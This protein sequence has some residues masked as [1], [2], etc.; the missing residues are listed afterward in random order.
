MSADATFVLRLSQLTFPHHV[1]WQTEHDGRFVQ[2]YDP[3]RPGK[4]I[5]GVHLETTSDP[6]KAKRFGSE[7]AAGEFWH[8]S[9]GRR[10]D[11]EPDRPLTA[12]DA[13]I[14]PLDVA[15]AEHRR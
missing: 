9:R 8:A 14:L 10:A 11:G 6:L 2:E 4:S 13:V 7:L 1:V 15:I 12:F 5:I 3:T